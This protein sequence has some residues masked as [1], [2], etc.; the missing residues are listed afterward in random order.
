M[1]LYSWVEEVSEPFVNSTNE[2]PASVRKALNEDINKNSI[3]TRSALFHQLPEIDELDPE[4]R[5]HK[6]NFPENLPT[7]DRSEELKAWD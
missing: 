6:N 7:T 1:Q 2:E 3:D 4:E 5:T